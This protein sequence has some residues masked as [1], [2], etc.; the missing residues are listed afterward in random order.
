MTNPITPTFLGREPA[1]TTLPSRLLLTGPVSSAVPSPQ[2]VVD[3][4]LYVEGQLVE[5][6]TSLTDTFAALTAVPDRLA[7]IDIERPSPTEIEAL[8]QHFGLHELLVED[9]IQAH[10]RPKLERYDATL[11]IVLQPA[12]YLDSAEEVEFGEIHVVVGPDY[13]VTLRH[14]STPALAPVRARLAADSALPV[15][16]PEAILYA[17]LDQV[18]DGYA[19]VVRGLENDAE[20]IEYQVFQGDPDVSRRIYSLSREVG[21]FQRAVRPLQGMLASLA[22][23]FAKY[24]VSLPLRDYLRDVADHLTEVREHI[25]GLRGALRDILTV[26]ATLTTQRQNEEIRHLNEMGAA[27]NDGMLKVSA[28]AAILFVPSLVGGIYGMNFDHMPELQWTYGYP[29]ALG[30]MA[31]MSVTLWAVFRRK[32]WL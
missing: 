19:P 13:I 17:V 32:R 11:F 15:M 23:G 25:D 30:L 21:D 5:R 22:A 26:N 14:T 3:A 20:E 29:F 31:A 4:A 9:I 1:T 6:L 18:V 7:W 24:G 27:Q 10:Q 28:W 16:G 12:S 8:A 2:G